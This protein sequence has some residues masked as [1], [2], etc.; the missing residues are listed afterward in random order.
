M[1]VLE[2]QASKQLVP[3]QFE[4]FAMRRERLAAIELCSQWERRKSRSSDDAR[5]TGRTRLPRSG[6]HRAAQKH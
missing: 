4:H 6:L 2:M 5:E 3:V 1:S